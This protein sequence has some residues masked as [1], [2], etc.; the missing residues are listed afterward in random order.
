MKE[1]EEFANLTGDWNPIHTDEEYAQIKFEGCVVHGALLNGA[2]SGIIGTRLPGPGTLVAR[3]ELYF[4]N[5]CYIG[6]EVLVKV[7]LTALRK[8]STVEFSC[9]TTDNGK[10]VLRGSAKLIIPPPV[11]DQP[12]D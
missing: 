11:Q 3:Q 8:L 12:Q 7:R 9:T 4:P 2:V 6:E 10:V 5:P 1:V